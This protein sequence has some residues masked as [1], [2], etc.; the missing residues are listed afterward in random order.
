MRRLK[1][2]IFVLAILALLSVPA[3]AQQDNK[4]WL[5]LISQRG[6]EVTSA[7]SRLVGVGITPAE[8][9]A[10]IPA[11]WV[12]HPDGPDGKPSWGPDMSKSP[13]LFE[14]MS[15]P[16]AVEPG[17]V[18]HLAGKETAGQE[19]ALIGGRTVKLPPDVY[20]KFY[21]STG[22]CIAGEKLADGTWVQWPDCPET[23]LRILARDGTVDTILL[24]KDGRTIVQTENPE[25]FKRV[26]QAFAD[27]I[28]QTGRTSQLDPR[29]PYLPQEMKQHAL[30]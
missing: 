15:G 13:P 17:K 11:D 27:V 8:R 23:P 4:A 28:Q 21:I 7:D 1:I 30:P 10:H 22:Q 12:Q 5:P 19:I 18:T 29:L 2:W 20:T 6:N 14:G 3:I 16:T 24:L 26:T 9:P 25:T